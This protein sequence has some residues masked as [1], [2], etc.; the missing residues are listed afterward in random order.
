M[1]LLAE[2]SDTHLEPVLE[3]RL[4]SVPVAAA[5]RR[6]ILVTGLS[7][8][9][10][11]T[12]IGALQDA[13]FHSVEGVPLAS[14]PV[15]LTDLFDHGVNDIAVNV[16]VRSLHAGLQ[17]ARRVLA[18]RATLEAQGVS[19]LLWFLSARIPVLV[20]RYAA[21]GR[22]H[23]LGDRLAS[24]L[25]AE[26]KMLA[27]LRAKAD[28]LLD[29]SSLHAEELRALVLKRLSVNASVPVVISSFGF[30]YGTPID[31]ELVFD[32][33]FLPN[34]YWDPALR[35]LSGLDEQVR[36]FVMASPAAPP[37]LDQMES[38]VTSTVRGAV[39]KG[40]SRYRVAIGCTGGHHRSVTFVVL[41]AERLTAA[42]F[43][44]EVHHRD[45]DHI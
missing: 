24:V 19:T 40:R 1:T 44:V 37:L 18:W 35:P 11:T 27:D 36:S 25:E 45:L 21:T 16:G 26:S 9:G 28:W 38:L 34:P 33:R 4:K 5:A 7:G 30:K 8:A 23:P 41:L 20:T 22:T 39:A 17:M 12:V 43:D 13:G 2:R 10:T 32:V 29:T 6:V 15:V 14:L 31:A 42:G 3:P